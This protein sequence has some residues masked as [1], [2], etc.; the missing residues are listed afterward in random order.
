MRY[1]SRRRCDSGARRYVLI[2]QMLLTCRKVGRPEGRLGA[3]HPGW[4][5][6]ADERQVAR[7]RAR[8]FGRGGFR[9]L[10]IDA[11]NA[12][13]TIPG[14][15]PS[16]RIPNTRPGFPLTGP[17]FG[18]NQGATRRRSGSADEKTAAKAPTATAVQEARRHE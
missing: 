16:G 9:G 8:R 7:R 18:T 5:Q 4:G 1:P 13:V 11:S 10:E 3:R 2:G 6:V 14:P 12:G 15:S 17:P